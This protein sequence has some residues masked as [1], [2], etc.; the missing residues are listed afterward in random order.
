MTLLD[1]FGLL[2]VTMM[3]VFYALERRHTIYV[4]AFAGA[5]A[6]ATLSSG[7]YTAC[8]VTRSPRAA[9]H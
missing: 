5:C 8:A 7:H 3:L 4:L 1:G 2:A 6:G 9:S